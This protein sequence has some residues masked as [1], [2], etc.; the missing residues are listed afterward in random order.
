MD[1][2]ALKKL[3]KKQFDG[4]SS[5]V[6]GYYTDVRDTAEAE[7][8]E[9]SSRL[10]NFTMH[11]LTSCCS[12][13]ASDT[14][15]LEPELVKS[16]QHCCHGYSQL[17]RS[18]TVDSTKMVTGLKTMLYI[19][20]K[21][22][23]K[24]SVQTHMDLSSHILDTVKCVSPLQT[25]DQVCD[26][27]TKFYSCLWNAA[28]MFERQ[29]QATLLEVCQLRFSAL[30]I[31]AQRPSAAES[32][33]EKVVIVLNVFEHKS[34][35]KASS[36]SKGRQLS[37][38]KSKDK[39]CSGKGKTKPVKG[40]DKERA[41]AE[42]KQ[43]D[44][45][46]EKCECVSSQPA[47]LCV[48]SLALG[49][50]QEL[51][52]PESVGS[53]PVLKLC[54]ALYD[55]LASFSILEHTLTLR[56][57][58]CNLAHHGNGKKLAVTQ[59][60]NNFF[61]LTEIVEQVCTESEMKANLTNLLNK[62]HTWAKQ[63][64]GAGDSSPHLDSIQW[65]LKQIKARKVTSH[66]LVSINN[67]T[68]LLT[69]LTEI[70]SFLAEGETDG[71]RDS[72]GKGETDGERDSQGKEEREKQVKTRLDAHRCWLVL[73]HRA[74]LELHSHKT[75]ANLDEVHS[76]VDRQL[77]AYTA[78]IDSAAWSPDTEMNERYYLGSVCVKLGHLQYNHSRDREAVPF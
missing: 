46:V 16:I 21:L 42:G 20:A 12:L 62:A 78:A 29:G 65:L 31:L 23:G 70:Q 48:F 69:V 5:E 50:L 76:Q 67:V 77:T 26:L 59:V 25:N 58:M 19:V 11:F 37:D 41:Q 32:C 73:Y 17:C 57:A 75:E 7:D 63:L 2:P 3:G 45:D 71:E 36:S 60:L 61:N 54:I 28:I 6:Q 4:L 39:R 22:N 1:W 38:G 55:F 68:L 13:L 49:L 53:S 18:A 43:D 8:Q 35:E 66:F 27:I 15:P 33:L 44:D 34:K 56:T 52:K 74:L 14:A 10:Y 47:E 40:R 72:Q 30:R 9:A 64:S 24:V 51:P